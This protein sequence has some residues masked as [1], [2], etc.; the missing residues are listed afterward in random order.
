VVNDSKIIFFGEKKMSEL[1]EKRKKFTMLLA[2]LITWI[3]E[4]GYE[5]EIG[6][7][8]LK[9]MPGSL[10]FAG[11][12]E[13]LLLFKDGTWLQNTEDYR[14]AGEYW[15]TLDPDC[16][17]GGNFSTPDGDHFSITFGGKS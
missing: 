16:R 6:Q 7:D 11:L 2:Q 1:S 15:I 13:D 8:G 10:H 5:V 12:A 4:Q 9:H 14:F 3:I 17:W